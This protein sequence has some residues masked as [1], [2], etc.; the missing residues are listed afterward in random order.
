MKK[1]LLAGLL[2]LAKPAHA[3]EYKW[4]GQVTEDGA[5]LVYGIPNSDGIQLDFHCERKTRKIVV[6]FFHEPK[7][8]AN[9]MRR[10]IRLTV[11]GRDAGVAADILAVG[12]RDELD[13][14]FVFQGETRMSPQLRRILSEGGTLRVAVGSDNVEIPLKGIAK[15]TRQLF[16]S[17][18]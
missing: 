5:R 4:M 13:D 3:D 18:P 10:T 6:V 8:A 11:S 9:E 17:C 14:R 2:I 15:E 7:Q 12:R 1:L 16:A